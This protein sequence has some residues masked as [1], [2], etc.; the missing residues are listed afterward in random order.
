MRSTAI[1]IGLVAILDRIVA[2][3]ADVF[4]AITTRTLHIVHAFEAPAVAV[5][6]SLVRT[7]RPSRSQP[8][9]ARLPRFG[10]ARVTIID[11]A[12]AA[13][14]RR[15]VVTIVAELTEIGLA[16]AASTSR[17][18][19]V[20]LLISVQSKNFSAGNTSADHPHHAEQSKCC[21]SLH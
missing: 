15:Y 3:G 18:N 5:A 12:F 16:I 19:V 17:S 13:S 21:P 9:N 4:M 10:R 1:R 2:L 6:N 11:R 8:A 7:A 14:I 20:D